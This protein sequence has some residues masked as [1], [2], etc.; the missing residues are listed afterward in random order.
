MSGIARTK[1]QECLELA[2]AAEGDGHADVSMA[3]DRVRAVITLA[4]GR[5]LQSFIRHAAG[6]VD[7]PIE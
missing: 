6:R 1:R 7:R 2:C 4:G 3:Q 5:C